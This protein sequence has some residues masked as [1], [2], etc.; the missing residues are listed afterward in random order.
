MCALALSVNSPIGKGFIFFKSSLLFDIFAPLFQSGGAWFSAI[1]AKIELFMF[2]KAVTTARVRYPR[3]VSVNFTPRRA[4]IKFPAKFAHIFAPLIF[5]VNNYGH[6]RT[7]GFR[8][9][10]NGCIDP[11]YPQEVACRSLRQP[12]H[13][14]RVV[15][16][17]L[18]DGF[19]AEFAYFDNPSVRLACG[20]FFHVILCFPLCT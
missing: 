14:P 12:P 1:R 13:R 19:K 2:R 5:A 18:C 9:C 7:I 10:Y 15:F 20:A 8:G 16:S 11:R 3:A 17:K 4:K 6:I